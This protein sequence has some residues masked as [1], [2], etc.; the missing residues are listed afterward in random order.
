VP[1][2]PSTAAELNFLAKTASGADLAEG[3]YG[4]NSD[5]ADG[6]VACPILS[7]FSSLEKFA[8]VSISL[9]LVRRL[10]T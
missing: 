8:F 2:S 5:S 4:D 6:I 9:L 3:A 1:L 7:D 10:V